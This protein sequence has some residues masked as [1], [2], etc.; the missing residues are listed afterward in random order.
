MKKIIFLLSL[1]ISIS[2]NAQ[3]S[4]VSFQSVFSIKG[5]CSHFTTDN[6]GNIYTVHK[7]RITKYSPQGDSLCS[8]SF[9]WMGEITSIDATNALRIV[10]FSR[11]LNRLMILDN[12]LSVQGEVIKLEDLG[13][14]FTSLVCQS[15]NNNNLWVYN[16][17]E[18]RLLRLNKDFTVA[19]N[20]GNLTQVL[21]ISIN[22]VFIAEYNN[23]LYVS[24]PDVGI[25]V[26]DMFAGYV[27]T[28]PVKEKNYFQVVNNKI[29]S[30]H[31]GMKYDKLNWYDVT[32][33]S[34]GSYEL[35]Y[36]MGSQFRIENSRLYVKM[37][38]D[39]PIDVFDIVTGKK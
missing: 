26:F 39:G 24:D 14:Q 1:L 17:E 34:Q 9:K 23:Y 8:Q 10:A 5:P 11:D 38:G 22:P 29:Y 12:T 21:G 7:D 3:D 19:N 36:W 2:V 32:D 16:M 4:L 15:P 30:L 20:S 31:N 35:D 27:K 18:F 28:L 6:L 37:E 25:L 33:H 13:L